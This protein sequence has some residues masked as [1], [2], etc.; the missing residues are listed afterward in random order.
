MTEIYEDGDITKNPNFIQ[1]RKDLPELLEEHKGKM[2]VY[3][4]GERIAIEDDYGSA[5]ESAFEETGKL[6][7]FV[8]RI[9]P[10]DEL[11]VFDLGRPK[12]PGPQ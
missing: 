9:L 1:F 10:D 11:P 6:G 5:I 4:D 3:L 2:A 7:D 12:R 8:F